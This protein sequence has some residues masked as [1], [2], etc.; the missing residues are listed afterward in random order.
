MHIPQ[1][2]VGLIIDELVLAFRAWETGPFEVKRI[3]CLRATSL[4]STAWV[5]PSQ[6][7]LFSTV[8]LDCIKTVSRWCLKTRPGPHGVSRHVRTLWLSWVP[9]PASDIFDTALLRLTTLRNL[10]RLHVGRVPYTNTDVDDLCLDALVPIFSSVA[11]TLKLLRCTRGNAPDE[12]YKTIYTLADLLPNLTDLDLSCDGCTWPPTLGDVDEDLT[13]LPRS[14]LPRIH[15]SSDK[16]PPDPLA[17]KRFRFREL[18]FR[19]SIPPS[20]PLLEYCQTH[21]QA[22]DLWDCGPHDSY[23]SS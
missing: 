5:D 15:L 2:V 1:D 8:V 10:Q 18:K 6:R 9:S 11:G 20:L 19:L 17:F 21:L 14:T 4:V 23:P 22:L 7:H 12:T 16:I 13:F 3:R